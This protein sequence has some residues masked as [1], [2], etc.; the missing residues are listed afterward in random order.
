MEYSYQEVLDNIENTR[1]L[2]RLPG[3]EVTA[4]ILEALGTPQRGLPFLH[5]AGT[6]GKGSVCAFLA[7]ILEEMGLK[8]GRF[9][10]PH[11][12]DFRERITVDGQMIGREDVARLG[13]LL[14]STDFGV[15]PTM[16]DYCLAMAVLYFKEQGCEI[17]VIETGLGGRLDSTNA[18]GKPEVAVITRI[19]YDHMALLG[20]SLTEIAREK[21]GILKDGVPAVFAPQEE[22]VRSVLCSFTENAH[23]V[24]EEEIRTAKDCRPVL[25]GVHQWENAAVA[26][27]AV[28]ALRAQCGR[29]KGEAAVCR[30]LLRQS[31]DD[32]E[33]KI[34]R[35]IQKTEWPGRMEILSEQPF[36]LVDGAHNGNGVLALKHSLENIYPGE[37]FHFVMGVMADKDYEKMVELLLPLAEDFLTV[38]PE[39]SRALQG[40]ELAGYIRNRGI[41]ARS[42]SNVQEVFE[43]LAGRGRTIAF[44]SLYFI[45]ELKAGCAGNALIK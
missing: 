2:G 1:R 17:A 42:L 35:G 32:F 30:C 44:G 31:D 24:T 23:I 19:G 40:E 9:T 18:L 16:F 21:A 14:L 43:N 27:A 38:T 7:S 22:S 41:P 39:G 28:R 36:L 33:Q 13:N 5:V 6:N 26:M 12:V 11:L 3:V 10:S 4:R 25:P 15:E 45:G 8:A 29:T 34:V 20:N 37:K